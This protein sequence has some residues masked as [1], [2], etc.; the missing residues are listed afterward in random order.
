MKTVTTYFFRDYFI[1][2]IRLE[3]DENVKMYFLKYTQYIHNLPQGTY[4]YI[5]TSTD[6]GEK[7]SGKIYVK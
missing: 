1:I 3:R 4:F 2:Q 7:C 5:F 6:G